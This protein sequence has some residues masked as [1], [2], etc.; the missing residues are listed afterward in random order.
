[1]KYS[2]AVTVQAVMLYS[3]CSTFCRMNKQSV[4]KAEISINQRLNNHRKM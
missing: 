1:M 4:R 3:C 2:T